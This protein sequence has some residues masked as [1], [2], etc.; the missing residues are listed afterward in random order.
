VKR[1]QLI[2]LAAMAMCA[3]AS[4]AASSASAAG[5]LWLVNGIRY[6]CHEGSGGLNTYSTLLNCLNDTGRGGTGWTDLELTGTSGL[7]LLD[8]SALALAVNKAGN[9]FKLKTSLITIECTSLHSHINLIGG[10]PAKDMATIEFTGCSVEGKTAT[11]C[12]VNSPGQPE[13]SITTSANTEVIY[14]GTEKEAEKEEGKLGDLFTPESGETFVELVVNGTK[15]PTFTKGEQEVKGSVIGE[16][17]P[18]ESM[19]KVGEQIFPTTSIAKGWQ[20]TSAKKV[21]EVKA[22]LKVFGVI[23]AVQIGEAEVMLGTNEEWGVVE[24]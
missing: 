10:T 13:G 3:F 4:A 6:D 9:V 12:H 7:L 17:K 20:W 21:K 2:L 11:E 14:L 8:Q 15:C 19:G 1:I 5:P 18:V 23:N 22:S 16:I 24:K